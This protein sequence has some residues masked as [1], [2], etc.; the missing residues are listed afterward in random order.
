M[1]DPAIPA[2]EQHEQLVS[3]RTDSTLDKSSTNGQAVDD[4]DDGDS[5]ISAV[6]FVSFIWLNMLTYR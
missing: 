5:A 1:Y 2:E 6:C 3:W 4:F